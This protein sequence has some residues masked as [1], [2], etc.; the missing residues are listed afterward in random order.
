M[1]AEM[2]LARMGIAFADD[3]NSVRYSAVNENFSW[4][5]QQG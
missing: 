5:Q 2:L 1:S 3:S 4:W